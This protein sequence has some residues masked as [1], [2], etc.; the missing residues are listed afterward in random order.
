[1]GEN[2]RARRD[3]I[4]LFIQQCACIRAPDHCAFRSVATRFTIRA[5]AIRDGSRLHLHLVGADD[6]RRL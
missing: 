1:L 6:A 4:S 5:I 3:P 2:T